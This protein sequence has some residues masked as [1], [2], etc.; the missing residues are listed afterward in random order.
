MNDETGPQADAAQVKRELDRHLEESA[1][2]R[3][4]HERRIDALHCEIQSLSRLQK[5]THDIVQ[6][7]REEY[8][9]LTET[10]RG[11]IEASQHDR[12]LLS[13]ILGSIEQTRVAS[14]QYHERQRAQIEQVDQRIDELESK[15]DRRIRRIERMWPVR[16]W[17]ALVAAW[18]AVLG[19]ASALGYRVIETQVLALFKRLMGD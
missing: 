19:L 2:T 14:A 1:G 13:T 8:R 9:A 10:I 15:L 3:D 7:N 11:Q 4:H 6:R 17:P 16:F 5:Q 12:A 18:L